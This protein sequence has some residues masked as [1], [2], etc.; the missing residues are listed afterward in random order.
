MSILGLLVFCLVLVACY[1]IIKYFLPAKVHTIAL[2]VV[3]VLAL[4]YLVYAFGGF[5]FLNAPVTGR[6]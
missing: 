1:F 6:R 2:C 4:L 3:G 5:G